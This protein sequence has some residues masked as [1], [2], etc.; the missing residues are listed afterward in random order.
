MSVMSGTRKLVDRLFKHRNTDASTK[1][2]NPEK[3][4]RSDVFHH[5][6]DLPL[7]LRREVLYW[8][9]ILHSMP[10]G[11]HSIRA[12]LPIQLEPVCA[13]PRGRLTPYWGSCKMSSLMTISRQWHHETQEVPYSKFPFNICRFQI[14]LLP[15]PQFCLSFLS[16]QACQLIRAVN[17]QV[18]H[19]Q[20]NDPETLN[21]LR[22]GYIA[23]AKGLPGL[24]KANINISRRS[25]VDDQYIPKLAQRSFTDSLLLL[26]RPFFHV[27][28]LQLLPGPDKYDRCVDS[29]GIP[30]EIMVQNCQK[31]IDEERGSKQYLCAT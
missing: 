18:S 5:Y 17:L 24:Q 30:Y 16:R 7:E 20:L 29:R 25:L 31:L 6:W 26:A 14:D 3:V 8:I 2:N 10:S 1:A 21:L 12:G 28:K 15:P 11:R 13:T 27:T 22:Q 19:D 4:S 9:I 23:V